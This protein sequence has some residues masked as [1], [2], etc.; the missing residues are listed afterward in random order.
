ML[1]PIRLAGSLLLSVPLLMSGCASL[2]GTP[3]SLTFSPAT[4]DSRRYDIYTTTFL[5][6]DGQ[7]GPIPSPSTAI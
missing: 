4:G 2:S 6:V 3:D 5:E 7:W 1:L